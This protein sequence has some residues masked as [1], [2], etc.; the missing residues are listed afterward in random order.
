[1]N[2][3]YCNAL[4]RLHSA[5]GRGKKDGLKGITELLERLGNPQR[6]MK[7]IHVVG[8]NGKGSTSGMV[9]SVLKEAGFKTGWYQSPFIEEFRERIQINGAMISE[10][11]FTS[12]F[13]RVEACG[14]RMEQEGKNYPTEFELLTAAAL[15]YYR[16]QGCDYAVLEAGIGGRSDATNGIGV[17][18]VV[19][20]TAISL[21][22]T[23]VLG[24][25]IGKIAQEKCGVLKPGTRAVTCPGQNQEAL[26]EIRRICG[27]K[28]IPLTIPEYAE[29]SM[30]SETSRGT[31]FQYKGIALQVALPGR[32]QVQNTVT[33]VETLRALERCG[34]AIPDW[35]ISKGIAETRLSG[36]LEWISDQP[37]ILADGSHN[38]QGVREFAAYL[39]RFFSDRRRI[40]ILGMLRDKN[41]QECIPI[42]AEQADLL[43]TV[44]ADTFRTLKAEETAQLAEGHCKE[45]ILCRK[46]E[47]AVQAACQAYQEG[48][49]IAVCG[50]LYLPG[51]AKRAVQDRQGE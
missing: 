49:L 39:N 3:R 48:D 43:I 20:L 10:E 46:M 30:L 12:V 13:E 19:A 38:P 1:M 33:A 8:T 29:V 4:E 25:T 23:D 44:E 35:A 37:P 17:P 24:E 26:E 16:E 28:G 32:Y 6:N 21:D 47:E 31:Q 2:Q 5:R 7:W 41:H 22:H 50:S 45:I 14:A 27:G 51:E 15:L 36:R 11:A 42:L 34:A 18:E 40:L 9:A